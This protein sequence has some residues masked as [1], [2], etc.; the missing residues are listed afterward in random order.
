MKS[1]RILKLFFISRSYRF[2]L[3]GFF[4]AAPTLAV[5]NFMTVIEAE[6]ADDPGWV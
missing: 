2:V 6:P 3:I 4:P 5:L 1:S